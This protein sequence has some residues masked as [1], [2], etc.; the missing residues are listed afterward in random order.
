MAKRKR[1]KGKRR[2]GKRKGQ[3]SRSAPGSK[4]P[5]FAATVGIGYSALDA[6]YLDTSRGSNALNLIIKGSPEE[7]KRGLSWLSEDVKGAMD[8]PRMKAARTGVLISGARYVPIAKEFYKPVNKFWMKMT[9]G[10]LG[11]L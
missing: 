7:R 8:S 6:I 1:S 4:K 2:G 9:K 10:K 3:K 11:P 5:P